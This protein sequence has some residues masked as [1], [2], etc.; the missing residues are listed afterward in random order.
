M[1][2]NTTS[3]GFSVPSVPLVRY[4]ALP[5]CTLPLVPKFA[6]GNAIAREVSLRIRIRIPLT[7]E[8]GRSP[9]RSSPPAKS[10]VPTSTANARA[11]RHTPAY[12]AVV[13]VLDLRP[14]HRVALNQLWVTSLLPK[15]V[16]ALGLPPFLIV[17]QLVEQPL[18]PRGFELGNNL[19][20]G[21]PFERLKDSGKIGSLAHEMKMIFEN[22]V[23]IEPQPLVLAAVTERLHND[24]AI[25]RTREYGY[26]LDDGGGDEVCE[27]RIVDFIS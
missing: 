1:K 20:G 26:P 23:R 25:R 27:I 13:N 9:A 19:T 3:T 21:V 24:L 5:S 14:Q 8:A 18:P 16:R 2:Y 6:L 7:T 11:R 17:R 22:D 10:S 4:R 15:L 12:R